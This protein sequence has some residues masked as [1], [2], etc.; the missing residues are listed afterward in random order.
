MT[1]FRMAWRWN[2]GP[3]VLQSRAIDDSGAVQPTRA[4]FLAARGAQF[5]YHNNSIQSWAV[6][7]AGDVSN[8]YA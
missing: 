4:A 2:G 8:V 3:A 1:R 7:A 6:S 5:R